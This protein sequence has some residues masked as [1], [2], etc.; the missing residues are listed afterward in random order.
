MRFG[1]SGREARGEEVF[2]L[3]IRNLLLYLPPLV[4]QILLSLCGARCLPLLLPLRGQMYLF[5][6]VTTVAVHEQFDIQHHVKG[7][8][9]HFQEDE[10]VDVA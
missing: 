2:L 1:E 7:L 6:D 5:F 9:A 10:V 8:V 4:Q 3:R